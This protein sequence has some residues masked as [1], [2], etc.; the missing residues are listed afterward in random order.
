M[1]RSPQ[2]CQ[3]PSGERPLIS[4]KGPDSSPSTSSRSLGS[5]MLQFSARAMF[6][7]PTGCFMAALEPCSP[8]D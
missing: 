7:N 2:V 3:R 5:E 1:N 6:I 4:S 8:S